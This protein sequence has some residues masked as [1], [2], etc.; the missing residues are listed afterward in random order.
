MD[1]PN[2]ERYQKNYQ[3]FKTHWEKNLRTWNKKMK[4][5]EGKKV[6]QYHKSFDYF[7]KRYKMELLDT[8]E[9]IPGISPTA[10]HI[11]G[12]IG[13][14]KEESSPLLIMHDVYHNQKA[15]KLISAKTDLKIINVPH[16]V[17]ALGGA[18]NIE[19]LFKTI[20]EGLTK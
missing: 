2:R 15:A 9:P 3:A 18:D 4:P 7:L 12:L 6:I 1:T 17:D 13:K 19:N 20:I 11:M 16:D 5:L 8:I 14:I 10:K